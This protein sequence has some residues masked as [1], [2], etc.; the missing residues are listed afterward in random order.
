MK[1]ALFQNPVMPVII[2]DA[3]ITDLRICC[4]NSAL[5]SV[6]LVLKIT[7]KWNSANEKYEAIIIVIDNF[8]S[9]KS[10]MV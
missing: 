9:H 7:G 8:P 6:N 1:K 5:I 4:L 10:T 3:D 2:L